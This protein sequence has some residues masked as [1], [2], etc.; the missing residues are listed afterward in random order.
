MSHPKPRTEAPFCRVPPQQRD[1][2]SLET[3]WPPFHTRVKYQVDLS[4]YIEQRGK[5]RY[6][7]QVLEVASMNIMTHYLGYSI[8]Y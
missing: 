5:V 3:V 6:A 2:S 7:W 4:V 1:S 8:K